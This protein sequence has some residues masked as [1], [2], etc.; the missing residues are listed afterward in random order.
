[1]KKTIVILCMFA[2]LLLAVIG[3][4]FSADKPKQ[5][6][7]LPSAS[8]ASTGFFPRST[9]GAFLPQEKEIPFASEV[10]MHT[11][12]PIVSFGPII[13]IRPDA[14]DAPIDEPDTANDVP[15]VT[16]GP[17]IRK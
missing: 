3:C 5:T 10:P 16:R 11:I 7:R 9:H 13:P 17:I 15:A 2:V 8:P 6:L 12:G 14:T 1:M 4:E